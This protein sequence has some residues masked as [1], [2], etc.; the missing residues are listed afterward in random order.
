MALCLVKYWHFV[1]SK[2][3]LFWATWTFFFL[4]HLINPKTMENVG[5]VAAKGS[6][7][8]LHIAQKKQKC[9]KSAAQLR[10]MIIMYSRSLKDTFCEHC[11]SRQWNIIEAKKYFSS[12]LNKF[13]FFKDVLKRII[14]ATI[15]FEFYFDENTNLKKYY[16]SHMVHNV[17]SVLIFAA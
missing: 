17:S 11:H 14:L 13:G 3:C 7:N 12:A 15:N 6:K 10:H 5:Y 9:C 4:C 2:R 16:K 1:K 8:V